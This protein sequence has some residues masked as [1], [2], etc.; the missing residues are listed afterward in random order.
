MIALQLLVLIVW[1]HFFA[2][3]VLQSDRMAQNKSKSNY[4][5]SF[6]VSVYTAPF[7]LFGWKFALLNGAAHWA[8]DYFTSRLNSKSWAAGKVHRFFVGVGADQAIHITTLMVTAKM[9][10]IFI[11]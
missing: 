9:L 10:G 3:F 4:W 11:V 5:L 6:H 7:F 2:D 8:V 1:I